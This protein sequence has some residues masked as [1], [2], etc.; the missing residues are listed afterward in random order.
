VVSRTRKLGYPCDVDAAMAR[1]GLA[2]GDQPIDAIEVEPFQ[3]S[4]QRLGGDEAHRGRRFAQVVST[5]PEAAVLDRHAHP[6]VARPR[7][8]WREL[9]Q[10]LV[11]LGQDLEGVLLRAG[12]HVEHLGD[13]LIGDVLVEEVAHRVDEHDA[14]AAPA[15]R[16]LQAL[17]PQAQVEA[18]LVGVA[19]HTAPALGERLGVAMR[20][21]G[22]DLRASRHRVP[23]GLGPLDGAH[24]CHAD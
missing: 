24:L 3:R 10:P 23:R 6:D 19:R 18:L 16:H 13:V 21:S 8:L 14:R 7:Q 22:R 17:R 2:T 1:P 9:D 12:H 20:A 5:V 15:Q 4:E 11:P